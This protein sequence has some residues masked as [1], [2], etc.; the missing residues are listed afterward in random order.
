MHFGSGLD[1]LKNITDDSEIKLG[2][3]NNRVANS[4]NK[5]ALLIYGLRHYDNELCHFG[6][7]TIVSKNIMRNFQFYH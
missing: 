7:G 5:L 6:Y 1:G 2:Y 4:K 3:F